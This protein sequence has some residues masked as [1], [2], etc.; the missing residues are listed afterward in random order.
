M[1]S[2]NTIDYQMC[3]LKGMKDAE[4]RFL[5]EKMKNGDEKAFRDIFMSYADRFF[6]WVNR[7]LVDP[8]LSADLVQEYF[9]KLWERRLSLSFDSATSFQAYSFRSLYNMS[10]N[11]LRDNDKLQRGYD[12]ILDVVDDPTADPQTVE[13]LQVRLESAIESLPDRCKEIFKMAKIQRKSYGEIATQ[14]G[15]SE[16]TV[17]VQVSKAYRLLR[18]KVN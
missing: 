2:R 16:N 3:L 13:E 7:I 10:L 15:I 18:S 14:L 5:L 6:L 8:D 1:L 4:V 9:I 17:K 12:I 11:H